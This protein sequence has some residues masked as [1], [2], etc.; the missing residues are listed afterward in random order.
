[1]GRARRGREAAR[2]RAATGAGYDSRV[3]LSR[4]RP[5]TLVADKELPLA[6]FTSKNEYLHQV[7]RRFT[8][9]VHNRNWRDLAVEFAKE[10]SE[11]SR[12]APRGNRG[13]ACAEGSE[14]AGEARG[15]AGGGPLRGGE[16]GRRRRHPQRHPHAG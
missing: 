8:T 16:P 7:Q 9:V 2:L 12:S 1:M 15:L 13:K 5:H 3:A 6:E 10:G 4:F 14:G 11:G